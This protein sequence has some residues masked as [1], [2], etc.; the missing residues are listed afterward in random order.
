V[1]ELALLVQPMLFRELPT[2][3]VVAAAVVELAL[4]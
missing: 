3:V 2:Q 1:V 4:V